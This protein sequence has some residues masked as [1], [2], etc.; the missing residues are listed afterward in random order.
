MVARQLHNTACRG[1]R[2][3]TMADEM[4]LAQAL[5][6]RE[7]LRLQCDKLRAALAEALDGWRNALDGPTEVELARIAELRAKHLGAKP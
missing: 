6:D 7:L 5:A 3:M 2:E 1:K 4:T